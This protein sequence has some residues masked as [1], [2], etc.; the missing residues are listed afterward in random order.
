MDTEKVDRTE[1]E[2][3]YRRGWTQSGDETTRLILELI[4]LGHSPIEVWRLYAAY[5]DHVLM[6]WRSDGD[7]A[8]KEAPPDFDTYAMQEVVKR[9][10]YDHILNIGRASHMTDSDPE[11]T[12]EV[13][14]LNYSPL[15][16]DVAL[17]QLSRVLELTVTNIGGEICSLC[18][19]R[20]DE[21]NHQIYG[22]GHKIKQLGEYK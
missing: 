21:E 13:L 20:I 18:D 16:H 19:I 14:L 3:A 9:G 10:G 2:A 22:R 8:K 17:Q 4:R 6:P 7:L 5:Q 1:A 11:K 15:L 12:E